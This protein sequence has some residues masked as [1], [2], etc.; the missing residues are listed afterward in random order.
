[1]TDPQKLKHII[2][3]KRCMSQKSLIKETSDKSYNI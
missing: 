2:N 3:N 1:M